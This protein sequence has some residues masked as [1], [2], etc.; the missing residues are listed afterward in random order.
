MF[1]IPPSYIFHPDDVVELEACDLLS[2]IDKNGLSKLNKRRVC[3]L[4]DWYDRQYSL[5]ARYDTDHDTFINVPDKVTSKAGIIHLVFSDEKAEEIWYQWVNWP[6]VDWAYKMEEVFI[7]YILEYVE[8]PND[9]YS[10]NDAAVWKSTM[11]VWGTSKELQDAILDPL[12][13]ME[14][15]GITCNGC[16]IDTVYMRYRGLKSVRKN[17]H[18]RATGKSFIIPKTVQT[19]DGE[20]PLEEYLKSHDELHLPN[21]FVLTA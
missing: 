4:S 7:D 5:E 14:R 16:I 8:Y 21:R 11:E 13:E 2:P 15:G 3:D 12:F 19:D 18:D 17:S 1:Y 6:A 9:V 20:M 10:N